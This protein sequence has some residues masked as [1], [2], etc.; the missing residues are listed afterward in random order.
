MLYKEVML[1]MAPE[2]ETSGLPVQTHFPLEPIQLS[3]HQ[4]E[5][6]DI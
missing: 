4:L 1:E 5:N 2:E 6:I 3:K